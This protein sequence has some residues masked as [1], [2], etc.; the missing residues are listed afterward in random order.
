M[1]AKAITRPAIGPEPKNGSGGFQGEVRHACTK[2]TLARL[3]PGGVGDPG[4]R[5][6]RGRVAR[7]EHLKIDGAAGVGPRTARGVASDRKST[8]LNSSHLGI[9]YAVF[10]LKKKTSK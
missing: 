1:K 7:A 10:C 8:R 3:R 2:L 4:R 5:Y 6:R 9:S